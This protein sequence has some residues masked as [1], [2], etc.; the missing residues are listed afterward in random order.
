MISVIIP[1]YNRE[2]CIIDLLNCFLKQ[3]YTDYEII[4]IDQSDILSE[5][6]KKYIKKC[7]HKLRYF[8]ISE[9]GRSLAKN[10]G[11]LQ[12]KG[13]LLLFCDDDIII[14]SNFLS[15]HAKH[16]SIPN[17]G[18]VSCR[19]VEEGQN[20][21]HIY[22]ALKT[23]FYGRLIN[24]PYSTAS[25]FVTSLNGGNMSIRKEALDK[26]GFFEEY[27]IGT[28]MVEEPDLAFRIIKNGYKIYFDSSITIMHYP[29]HNG[30]IALISTQR[31]KWFYFYFYNLLIFFVKYGRFFQTFFV[32][33][34]CIILSL[35]HSFKYKLSIKNY[36]H[37][38]S[39]FFKGY[40]KGY[41]LY[42]KNTHNKNKYFTP[43]R[44]DKKNIIPI[45]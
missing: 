12:A 33:I 25:G 29:Q 16:Y 42:K 11:I 17:I 5:A 26:S 37:M 45:L 2:Q 27:F 36:L 18:G 39:G 4:V 7:T 34:Y 8:H 3:D 13:D 1:T 19:L 20:P 38:I 15:T 31:A 32:F 21:V 6:K 30:N 35:K 9:R 23:T 40:Q 24:R 41:A 22:P 43:F 44:H 28:S 14:P 10:Y